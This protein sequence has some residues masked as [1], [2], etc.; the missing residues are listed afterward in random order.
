VAF[1][2]RSPAAH[3]VAA[4]SGRWQRVWVR[5]RPWAIG[6]F[7]ALVAGLLVHLSHGID[8]SQA[9][10]SLRAY[11]PGT[12]LLAAALA[13]A[14]YAVYCT[15][16]LL[17]R[18]QT[19]HGL[20]AARVVGI[21]FVSYAFNLNLGSLVGGVAMRYRLYSRL[22]L[23]VG[24]ITEVLALSLITNWLGY[25]FVGGFVFAISPP[26][27]PPDWK[28]GNGGLHLLG[29]GMLIAVAVYVGACW[30]AKRRTWRLRGRSVELPAGRIA[31]GQLALS[32]V[33][34]M[35]IA[36]VVFVLLRGR[37]DY[38]AV[39]AVLLAAAVAGVVAHI[40][41]GL[42]VLEAVFLALL[43]HRAGQGELMAALLSYRALYYLVPLALATVVFATTGMG[44]QPD[45]DASN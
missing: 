15:Y 11:R 27:L 35:L 42:G 6:A 45:G 7:F 20:P 23:G 21:G 28:V 22:G 38:A 9:G 16:D 31:L 43:S 25:L 40:P 10:Q 5:L 13:F 2:P 8:W 41:A 26:R 36:A 33:N 44:A 3:P 14:S 32:S 1:T 37:I 12:L 29:I 19:G 39:L 18:H 17:G 30:R 4:A 24:T 34:W